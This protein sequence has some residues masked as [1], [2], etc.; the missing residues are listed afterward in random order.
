[1]R[2]IPG[3]SNIPKT[4]TL[5]NI[6]PTTNMTPPVSDSQV[7]NKKSSYNFDDELAIRRNK[8]LEALNNK[9]VTKDGRRSVEALTLGVGKNS[10]VRLS[11]TYDKIKKVDGIFVNLFEKGLMVCFRKKKW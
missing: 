2:D 7:N 6:R 8:I 11:L 5:S 9:F 3:R 10:N 4:Q 1:M